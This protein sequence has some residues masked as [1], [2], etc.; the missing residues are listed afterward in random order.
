MTHKY[1]I[2]GLSGLAFAGATPASAQDAAFQWESSLEIGVDST[3]S[4]DD[5]AAE[6][7]DS[8]LS[9]EAAFEAA[10]TERLSLFGALTLESVTDASA[11]RA[12][13]DLGLYIG[14]LGLSYSFGDTVIFGGK[15]SPVFAVAWDAA[16]GFYGAS[17]AEDYELSEQIGLALETP[18]G[19]AG[20]LSFAVFYAD[21]TFM[22]DSIGTKRGRNSAADGGAGNTGKFNNVALHYTH[23]LNDTTTAW[24]GARYLSA[25]VGDVSDETG[26]VAGL[27]HDFGNGFDMIGEVAHF[28]GFGGGGDDATYV[29]L[30]GSYALGDWALSA[31]ATTINTSG[32]ASDHLISLGL[33]RTFAND[34]ELSIGVARFDVGGEKSTAFGIAAEIPFGA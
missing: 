23:S 13:D 11:D 33:D 18:L 8:Y 25:S 24:V 10:L 29:T 31:S 6:L 21:D 20:V 34:I 12:F 16:P 15:I 19:Q 28:N 22:S 17:L 14:E 1:L 26:L 7:S 9:L 3:L 4:A 2:A 32:A 30:G 5:P 27:A